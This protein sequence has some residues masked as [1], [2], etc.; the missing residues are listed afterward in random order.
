V[1]EEKKLNKELSRLLRLPFA[2]QSKEEIDGLMGEYR[3]IACRDA[4]SLAHFL[5]AVDHLVDTSS[6][7][8]PPAALKEAILETPVPEREKAPLGCEICN[9]SG[10]RSFQ[11]MV[12]P[13]G[14]DAYLADFATF[15]GCERGQWMKAKEQER[16][17]EVSAKGNKCKTA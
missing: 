9:G 1:I 17:A 10:W 5:G 11:K 14:V 15:C 8:P 6:R 4:Q 16:K 7:V 2:P 13:S 12:H 3:R